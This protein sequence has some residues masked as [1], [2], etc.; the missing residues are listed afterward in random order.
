ML[1]VLLAACVAAPNIVFLS[2]DTLRA[3]RLGCYGY[4]LDTSPNLDAFAQGARLFEDCVCE[5]PLT[6]PS[7]GSMLSSRFPRSTGQTRNGLRMPET[8]PLVTERFRAAGYQT[9][10]VQS[11]WSLKAHLSGLDRGFDRFEDNLAMKRWGVLKPERYGDKVTSIAPSFAGVARPVA[12]VLLLD[13]LLGPARALPV[14]PQVQP[15][16]Q[17]PV[18]DGSRESDTSPVRFRG[19]LRG[20][21]YR[22]SSGGP[23]QR[24]H[25][26]PF[27]RG[28]RGEPLRARIL[29]P[30]AAD[31]S[32]RAPH[33]IH[34]QGSGHSARARGRAG[35][36]R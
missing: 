32:D 23:P 6:A 22:P 16:G 4:P 35:S 30:W 34:H 15:R 31:L 3:D 18:A 13:P 10:C 8:V 2:V 26:C 12:P 20:P 19:G 7:F 11:N 28:S 36:R 29:G 14:P 33:S 1:C 5:V 24:E 17:S 21:S 9:F 27:R 25:L